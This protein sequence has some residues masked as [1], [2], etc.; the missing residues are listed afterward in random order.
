MATL[1]GERTQTG[2]L[3]MPDDYMSGQSF[4][5]GSFGLVVDHRGLLYDVP[6]GV[7][8]FGRL[9]FHFDRHGDIVCLCVPPSP[10][11]RGAPPATTNRGAVGTSPN[12]Q[13][14][15]YQGINMIFQA[16]DTRRAQKITRRAVYAVVPTPTKRM[17]SSDSMVSFSRIDHPA[18]IRI[19]ASS[20]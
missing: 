16:T 3:F 9:E 15:L 8:H 10:L 6:I 14:A 12:H 11:A 17:E 2:S 13:P 5:F 4:T 7:M 19:R 20:P 18:T 1:V